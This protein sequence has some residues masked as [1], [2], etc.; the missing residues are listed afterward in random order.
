MSPY[1]TP[2]EGLQAVFK[3][4]EYYEKPITTETAIQINQLCQSDPFFI[5]C[6]MAN[7]FHGK[8]LTT[9]Q[10][11][12]DTVNYEISDRK[13]EMSMTW[14]EYIELTLQRVNDIHAKKILLHMSKHADRDWTPKELK[15]TLKL[16]LDLK[17]IQHRL[18]TLVKADLLTEGISDIDY[19]GLKDGTLYLIL[20]NRF[21][22]EISSFEPDLKKQFKGI[23]IGSILG[24]IA[25][26]I[27]EGNPINSKLFPLFGGKSDFTDD[28]VLTIAVAFSLLTGVDYLLSYKYFARKYTVGFSHQFYLWAH[29]SSLEPLN[30]MGNG[31]A[32]RVSPVAFAKNSV[33]EVLG[34]AKKSSEVT[35]NH[36]EGIKGAQATALAVFLARMGKSKKEIKQVITE[37]FQYNLDRTLDEIRPF[38]YFK[39]T[40]PDSVPESIIAFL[41]SESVVD[42]V[43]KAVSLGGDSDTM[44][45]IAGG[46]AHACYKDIP[47]DIVAEVKK[48]LPQEFL[49]IMEAFEQ[50][51]CENRNDWESEE[52]LK[53]TNEVEQVLAKQNGKTGQI[54]EGDR[55]NQENEPFF[56]MD[57]EKNAEISPAPVVRNDIEFDPKKYGL[58]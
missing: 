3:Y 26:S 4:S 2:D 52:L 33:E 1:L 54:S 31:S 12:I 13:S 6:V 53:L 29:S 22:K 27:Y 39:A 37:R 44:A 45:C 32:M 19:R 15:D 36:P 20:R 9:R 8:D 49:M 11:V 58:E 56:S 48:R 10:S 30:S 7:E 23:F 17:G 43:R 47:D 18:R 50:K 51:F 34:E 35:H 25:G 41:E 21:E 46:I 28:T 40:A 16:D 57:W 55:D 24:D 38:Y 5:S 14:G 42:A